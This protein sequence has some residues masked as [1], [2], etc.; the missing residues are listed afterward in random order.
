MMVALTIKEI[1][2]VVLG[3]FDNLVGPLTYLHL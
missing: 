3:P 1:K 2:Y